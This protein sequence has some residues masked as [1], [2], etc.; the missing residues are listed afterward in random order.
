MVDD[1][2]TASKCGMQVVK[3][4]SAVKHFVK[5]KKLT[6][7]ENKCARIHIGKTR[8]DQCMNIKVNKEPIRESHKE[9]YLGDYMTKNANPKDTIQDR[10]Q[11]GYGIL[12]KMRAILEDIPLG[13]ERFKIGCNL[14]ESWFI[15]GT[16]FN[17]EIWNAFNENDI[18][19][20]QVLDRKIL[21]LIL[22]AQGK[23]PCEMLYLETGA[24]EL[25]H[26]IAVRR[27]VYLQTIL[28]KHDSEIIKKIYMAQKKSPC[29]GDWVLLVEEDK[30]KYNIENSDE[31]IAE[32]SEYVYKKYIKKQVRQFA[33]TELK[34]IQEEH[35]KVKHIQFDSLNHPQEYLS[36]NLFNNRLSSL[37]FNLRCQSVKGVKANFNNLYEGNTQCQFKCLN[38][39]DSQEHMLTCHELIRHLDPQQKET[40]RNVEYGDLFGNPTKQLGITQMFRILLK[41]RERLL[42]KNHEPAYHGNSS[43]P[44]G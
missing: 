44:S 36:G 3:T 11:K 15:N 38:K 20:L 42:G 43:G 8:C 5:L 24:I 6:L 12:S 31:Q 27:L 26:V 14:R 37:L 13:S 16:L 23:V 7:S 22:G 4:N 35:I 40:L 1:I 2:L 30:I 34:E 33:L 18:K 19:M 32:M 29:T 21:R 9:K 39:E 41:T 10:K 17:S 25:K 28:K